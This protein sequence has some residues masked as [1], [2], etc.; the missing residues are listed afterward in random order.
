MTVYRLLQVSTAM[1]MFLTPCAAQVQPGSTG[2]SI[3]KTDKSVSGGGEPAS[4][5][6]RSRAPVRT[7]DADK[8]ISSDSGGPKAYS[9]P[10]F[11]GIRVDWC[12]GDSMHG[13]GKSAADA[14]CRSKGHANSTS[15]AWE[16]H[17]P[18]IRMISRT[19]CD[20][21]CGAFTKVVCE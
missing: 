16:Y 3:G 7:R 20:G 14:W 5:E 15:F 2:G 21:F 6:Q 10:T 18:A 8:K 4:P 11:D 9:T 1:A 13:C 17:S 12:L 19:K